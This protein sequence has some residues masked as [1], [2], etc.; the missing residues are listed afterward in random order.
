MPRQSIVDSPKVMLFQRPEAQA[1]VGGIQVLRVVCGFGL[2]PLPLPFN[3]H[4]GDGRA[5]HDQ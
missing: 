4:D 2:G 1:H 5:D 3:P